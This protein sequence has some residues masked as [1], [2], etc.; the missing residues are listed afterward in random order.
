MG[1][2]GIPDLLELALAPEV[3]TVAVLGDLAN[4]PTLCTLAFCLLGVAMQFWMLLACAAT[5]FC[6]EGM[7]QG[8]GKI[9]AEI[10]LILCKQ[11][12]LTAE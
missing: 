10:P 7:V 12:Q 8:A 5:G 6:L 3:L 9:W 4:F 11:T 1:S 2:V